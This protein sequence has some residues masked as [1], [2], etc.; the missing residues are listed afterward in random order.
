M[1]KKSIAV[2]CALSLFLSQ[3]LVMSV[4]AKADKTA[5]VFK[6][7]TPKNN[8]TGISPNVK[9]VIKYSENIYKGANFSKIKLSKSTKPVKLKLVISKTTL[10]I[11]Y[12]ANL[13]NSRIYTLTIPASAIKDKAGNVLKKVTKIKFKIK[14]KALA[15]KTYKVGTDIPAGEYF[16]GNGTN[17]FVFSNISAPLESVI[18]G[19]STQTYIT[20]DAGNYINVESGT[21]YPV[22]SAPVLG[23]VDG[24]YPAGFYK[25]GRDIPAGEYDLFEVSGPDTSMYMICKDS[26]CQLESVLD[27]NAITGKKHV[28]LAEGQYILFADAYMTAA[29]VE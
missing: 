7:S 19:G 6:S 14:A 10:K 16:I 27:M 15:G 18:T 29:V 2:L 24:K 12:S 11:T 5:P 25:V 4:S 26:Y 3:G 17:W 20:V 22:A 9:I 21:L 28:T 23:A 8:A 13:H 1:I